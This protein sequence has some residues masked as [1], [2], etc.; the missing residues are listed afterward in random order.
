[1]QLEP[2]DPKVNV[3]LMA[4]AALLGWFVALLTWNATRQVRKHDDL[5]KRVN[6][7]ESTVATKGDITYLA[8]RLT[9]IGDR[10]DDQNS[11][12]LRILVNRK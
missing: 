11:Q 5:E 1:M 4:F 7:L 12:I 9:E 8:N 2:T 6:A 10:S 3:L